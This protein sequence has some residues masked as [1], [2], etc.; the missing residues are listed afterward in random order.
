MIDLAPEFVG[1]GHG[2]PLTEDATE[3]LRIMVKSAEAN[4]LLG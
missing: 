1:V 3:K 2:D 4:G